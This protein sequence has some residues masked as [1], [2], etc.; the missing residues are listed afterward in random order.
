MLHTAR[1][2]VGSALTVTPVYNMIHS[3]AYGYEAAFLYFGIGQ[4]VIGS[5]YAASNAGLLYTAKG[6]A[7]LLIPYTSVLA[8]LYG[9][10]GVFYV[11]ASLNIAAA[12]LAVAVLKPL[13]KRHAALN[14]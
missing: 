9:W 3:P 2:S 5:K 1:R 4:G 8:T 6:T 14:G 10:K 7:A 13:R 11:A 12:L